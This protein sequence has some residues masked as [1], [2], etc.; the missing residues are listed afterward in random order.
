MTLDS[1]RTTLGQ[2]LF[3][4]SVRGWTCTYILACPPSGCLAEHTIYPSS[5][6]PGSLAFLSTFPKVNSF[7]FSFLSAFDGTGIDF[8]VRG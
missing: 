7:F 2:I 4:G 5:P 1:A 6:S 8:F 3:S